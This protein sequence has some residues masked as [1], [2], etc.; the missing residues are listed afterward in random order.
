[1]FDQVNVMNYVPSKIEPTEVVENHVVSKQET[2]VVAM[3]TDSYG[4]LEV[5][6]Q[7]NQVFFHY[8]DMIGCHISEISVG[9]I[10]EFDIIFR[11]SSKR[12]CAINV[13][14]P[15][16]EQAKIE[17]D[18]DVTV[19]GAVKYGMFDKA[20]SSTK[21]AIAGY[22]NQRGKISEISADYGFIEYGKHGVDHVFFH[23]SE[24]IGCHLTE[25]FVGQD[26]QFD[27]INDNDGCH[28]VN[29][30]ITDLPK[31]DLFT[32][33]CFGTIT[34]VSKSYG[35]L[36]CNMEETT[37]QVFFQ[38]TSSSL[39]FGDQVTFT[40]VRESGQFLS[41]N[42]SIYYQQSA[43]DVNSINESANLAASITRLNLQPENLW[44]LTPQ[45]FEKPS[46]P[47]CNVSPM[48]VVTGVVTQV[49]P[50][51]AFMTT[52]GADGEIFLHYSELVDCHLSEFTVGSSVECELVE[53]ART[54]G[55][56]IRKRQVVEKEKNTNAGVLNL[57]QFLQLESQKLEVK[58]LSRTSTMSSR[59]GSGISSL[60][61]VSTSPS[62]FRKASAGEILFGLQD[63]TLER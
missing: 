19:I 16:P 1:M 38:N 53:K 37:M 35:F 56:N 17:S 8:A 49:F 40:L 15:E 60:L 31:P 26:L 3:V 9:S 48:K 24:L 44:G 32:R 7:A 14:I 57:K 52:K 6:G 58:R 50:D 61:E 11:E 10:L 39:K 34:S 4:F 59:R 27:F 55:K 54:C 42:L 28:A 18:S 51:Y 46:M 2:A 22:R 21:Q 23:Y 62:T 43:I 41:E 29:V 5:A 45:M 25:M 13:K 30:T 12:Y 47:S 20:L 36:S 63:C 33:H